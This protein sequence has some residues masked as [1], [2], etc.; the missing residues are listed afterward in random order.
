MD[1]EVIATAKAVEGSG[2]TLG[3]S[4]EAIG[5]GTP[6]RFVVDVAK[7]HERLTATAAKRPAAGPG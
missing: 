7:T 2:V 5:A 3:I 6:R 1:V 4:V